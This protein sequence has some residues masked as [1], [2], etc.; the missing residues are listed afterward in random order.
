MHAGDGQS[1]VTSDPGKCLAVT[2]WSGSENIG[3]LHNSCLSFMLLLE[4]ASN[5]EETESWEHRWNVV[6]T[7]GY[8]GKS[9]P[10][11]PFSYQSK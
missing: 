5:M 10:R 9:K 3:Q 1:V 4:E 2:C 8:V 6:E 7:E 11:S